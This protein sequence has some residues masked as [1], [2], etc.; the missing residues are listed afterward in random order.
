MYVQ[1]VLS[2]FSGVEARA[3]ARVFT[4]VEDYKHSLEDACFLI[5]RLASYIVHV[6]IDTSSM[7][8]CL[9][10]ARMVGDVELTVSMYVASHIETSFTVRLVQD[11]MVLS[12]VEMK[13]VSGSIWITPTHVAGPC[14]AS[15][16]P[17]TSEK[18]T[19]YTNGRVCAL[20]GVFHT[21]LCEMF[22]IDLCTLDDGSSID[23]GDSDADDY[24]AEDSDTEGSDTEDSDTEGSETDIDVDQDVETPPPP[25]KQ[26]SSHPPPAP[27]KQR[28]T[29]CLRQR[30]KFCT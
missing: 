3:R 11:M 12:R 28:K 15:M 17:I 21:F 7:V 27:K 23:F 25:R 10:R 26:R 16:I 5:A 20:E 30:T 4:T 8:R 19:V 6:S 13:T 1:A 22:Q 24:D 18:T 9:H 14:L 2:H 29:Y